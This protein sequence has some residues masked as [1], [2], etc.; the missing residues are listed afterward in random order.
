MSKAALEESPNGS[1]DKNHT[2]ERWCRFNPRELLSPLVVGI[3]LIAYCV[4][5]GEW[6]GLVGL[7]LIYL[8]W[9]CCAPNLNLADGCLSVL[10]TAV[11]GILG[12]VLSLHG[13]LVAA[14]A[15]GATWL[16]ASLESAY[17]CVP[18][19][20]DVVMDPEEDDRDHD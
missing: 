13:L 8:G 3:A 15:C 17:R 16:A 12:L 7:P 4:S 5:C 9:C 14:A 18:V 20:G 1:A 2:D 6:L 11:V 19:P 10:A